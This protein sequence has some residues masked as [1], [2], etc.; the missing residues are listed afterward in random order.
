[1]YVVNALRRFVAE[2]FPAHVRVNHT[3][4]PYESSATSSFWILH[5]R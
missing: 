2:H 4:E 5:V 3:H 1:M